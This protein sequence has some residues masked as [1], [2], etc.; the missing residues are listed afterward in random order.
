VA[1]TLERHG[2]KAKAKSKRDAHRY[3]V[4]HRRHGHEYQGAPVYRSTGHEAPLASPGRRPIARDDTRADKASSSLSVTEMYNMLAH[5][6]VLDDNSG[7]PR[8]SVR[9]APRETAALPSPRTSASETPGWNADLNQR[10]VTDTPS[11]FS[12]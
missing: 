12:K 3:E 8:Q 10:R 2:A 5:S 11:Q 7:A 9:A 6:A 4:V 1:Q